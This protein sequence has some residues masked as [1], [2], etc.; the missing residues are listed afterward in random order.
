MVLNIELSA[1]IEEAF[2]TKATKRGQSTEQLARELI[3]RET[4]QNESGHSE[5]SNG[6]AARTEERGKGR[7][8]DLLG[9]LQ[10]S[11]SSVAGFYAERSDETARE[12]NGLTR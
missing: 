12:E 9:A 10:A 8:D 5:K 7:F 4:G 1:S 2:R 6:E 11:S 3:E